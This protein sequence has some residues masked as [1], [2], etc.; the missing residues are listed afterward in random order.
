M[1]ATAGRPSVPAGVRFGSVSPFHVAMNPCHERV[2]GPNEC[3]QAP[4]KLTD[5]K[6]S[7]VCGR[8]CES[9][10]LKLLRRH[11]RCSTHH[12]FWVRMPHN[13]SFFSYFFIICL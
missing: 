9:T 12:H 7:C 10:R 3:P 1:S 13:R 8:K 5:S 2:F 4:E 6:T 11:S